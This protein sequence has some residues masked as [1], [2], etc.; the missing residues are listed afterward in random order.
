MAHRGNNV[1]SI[2]PDGRARRPKTNGEYTYTYDANKEPNVGENTDASV[3]NAFYVANS[4]HDIAYRYGFT[5]AAF[6]FQHDNFKKGGED[7]DPVMAYVQDKSGM[8]NAYFT[9]L[10]EWVY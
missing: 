6:N 2:G 10:P 5:E 4:V 9:T 3:V 7:G 1:Q 8:N